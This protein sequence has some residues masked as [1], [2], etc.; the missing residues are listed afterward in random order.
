VL[1]F[2]IVLI[3]RGTPSLLVDVHRVD[4]LLRYRDGMRHFGPAAVTVNGAAIIVAV[5]ALLSLRGT[6]SASPPRFR[7]LIVLGIICLALPISGAALGLIF[8]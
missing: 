5:G 3:E 2:N 1:F 4:G 7:A 6:K 8:R